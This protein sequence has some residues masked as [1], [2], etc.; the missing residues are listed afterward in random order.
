M[1]G[2][3]RIQDKINPQQMVMLRAHYCSGGHAATMRELATAAGYADYKMANLQYGNLAKQLY[4]AIGYPA[5]K[6][7]RSGKEYWILGLGEFI[8]RREFGLELHCVMRPEIAEAL[9][10][11][12]ILE[13][14]GLLDEM[15]D[16]STNL[17]VAADE[18][19]V[20][21]V[22]PEA[23]TSQKAKTSE[24]PPLLQSEADSKIEKYQ[25]ALGI[26]EGAKRILIITGKGYCAKFAY[27]AIIKVL[28]GECELDRER[29]EDLSLLTQNIDGSHDLVQLHGDLNEALCLSCG[30]SYTSE[31]IA[32]VKCPTDCSKCKE[33]DVILL[34]T[35]LDDDHLQIAREKAITCEFCVVAGSSGVSDAAMLIAKIAKQAGAYLIEINEEETELSEMADVFEQSYPFVLFYLIYLGIRHDIR[36]H[37]HT[38]S[39][40][41]TPDPSFQKLRPLANELHVFIERFESGNNDAGNRQENADLNSDQPNVPERK[42][43]KAKINGRSIE[44][45]SIPELYKTV[46]VFLFDKGFLNDIS[47]PVSSGQTRYFLAK[48]PVHPSGKNFFK[49]VEYGGFYL[50]AHN[51]RPTGIR[52]IKTFVE[53]LGVSFEIAESETPISI[54]GAFVKKQ[55]AQPTIEQRFLGSL[56]GLAA[57]D[58]L[59]T[60]V[61]FKPTGTFSP[62]ITIAGG[63]PFELNAGE[64]TDDTSMALC[65]ADSLIESAGFDPVDQMRRY[66]RWKD[67]GYLSSN[68]A[69]FDIGD[70]VRRALEKFEQQAKGNDSNAYCGS[71]SPA[72]AGNGSL[73]RLTPVPLFF[74]NDPTKAIK[75]AGESS[76]TTHGARECVDACRYFAAL[77][78]G[79]VQ[80]GSKEE[81]LSVQFTPLPGLWDGDPLA[82]K[83]AEIAGGA[84]KSP[85]PPEI[86]GAIQG[87]VIPSLHAALWA[88]Y[89]TNSFVDGALKVVN[90]G[91]DADTYGAIYGQLAGAYYGVESIPDEWLNIIAKR[92]LIESF[93]R[94]LYEAS[95]RGD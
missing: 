13:P 49:Q 32:E 42:I 7:P 47:T 24:I 73:M 90:L 84:F 76:R 26:L 66:C 50:E 6:S 63:G 70:T 86:S 88:F 87:Y 28:N 60:T 29:V 93:A 5:P 30:Y 51:N 94:K 15:L 14:S 79:A 53:S 74:A 35:R 46:L 8:D 34:G 27:S 58:A 65:L 33:Y 85:R 48:E 41:L 83:V 25:P 40:D 37:S 3:Q 11:L 80:G 17:T 64:W 43:I 91:Y 22:A 12:R 10:R 61:E 95:G 2:F 23:Y 20:A 71:I 45:K 81:I 62:V 72:T 1:Y 69:A 67:D 89:H 16:E 39:A 68:G 9:E 18:T 59:G 36:N 75:L 19:E 21:S 38:A 57:C 78:I 55:G 52:Q 54:D 82:P 31:N 92:D 77:I 4:K 56:L 44:A